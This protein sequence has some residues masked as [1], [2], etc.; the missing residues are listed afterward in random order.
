[1]TARNFKCHAGRTYPA[2]LRA[3]RSASSL[4]SPMRITHHKKLKL[5]FAVSSYGIGPHVLD[6]EA[7]YF[8]N[9][10]YPVRCSS[11]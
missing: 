7:T 2:V 8:N 10:K 6:Y 11:H 4:A 3:F 5:V 9:I 1:M